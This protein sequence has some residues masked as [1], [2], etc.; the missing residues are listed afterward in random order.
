[1]PAG[2]G[3]SPRGRSPQQAR[4]EQSQMLRGLLNSDAMEARLKKAPARARSGSGGGGARAGSAAAADADAADASADEARPRGGASA[5]YDVA[6]EMEHLKLHLLHS[7][8]ADA[9]SPFSERSLSL[10][11]GR[12][13]ASATSPSTLPRTRPS[14]SPEYKQPGSPDGTR[15]W[16]YYSS[17]PR[18]L[19]RHK[20]PPDASCSS[21]SFRS[22]GR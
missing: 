5:N 18:P 21:S 20:S 13:R 4:S 17:T 8:E 22:V 14:T 7:T 2:M 1:M 11:T 12:R 9:S 16:A 3:L 10:P 15:R 19:S 6:R